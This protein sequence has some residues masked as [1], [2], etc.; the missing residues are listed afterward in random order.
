MAKPRFT[1]HDVFAE[2]KTAK[3]TATLKD[4]DGSV[5]ALVSVDTLT[6]TLYE[7][8]TGTIINSRSGSNIKNTG[9]GTLHA[10]SGAFTLTFAPDDMAFIQTD[11]TRE[12]HIALIEW[13]YNSGAD[14][15]GKEI[16]FQVE[17]LVK[18]S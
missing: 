9:G 18:V 6:L 4:E 12:W 7:E 15:G 3:I 17:N 11:P 16:A 14:D 10:T 1:L 13:T 5:L 2:K 8:V